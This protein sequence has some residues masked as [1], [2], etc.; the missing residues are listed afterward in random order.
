M[1]NV[2]IVGAGHYLPERVIDLTYFM[3]REFYRYEKDERVEGPRTLTMKGI[4]ETT[5]IRERRY[6]RE[7]EFSHHLGAKAAERALQKAG[8]E[9]SRLEIIAI[10]TET[11]EEGFP[12]T[13]AEVQKL[14]KVNNKQCY[15]IHVACSGFPVAVDKVARGLSRGRY[16]MAISAETLSKITDPTDINSTLFGDGAGAVVLYRDERDEIDT[17]D[18]TEEGVMLYRPVGDA[19]TPGLCG[20]FHTTDTSE[21]RDRLIYKSRKGFIRMPEGSRVLRLAANGMVEITKALHRGLS[22]DG[23]VKL[24]PHQASRRI[25]RKYIEGMAPT[26]R[27]NIFRNVRLRGNMSSAT[28]G[29]CFSEALERGLIGPGDRVTFASVGSGVSKAGLSVVL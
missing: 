12:S 16:G 27:Q 7:D 28:N 18:S 22:W 19:T 4:L 10:A 20:F 23:A 5:G 8:I 3:G 14:L 6:A 13:A 1:V 26:P 25:V 9:A 21:N 15:D 11:S 2:R 24:I 17:P 29:V